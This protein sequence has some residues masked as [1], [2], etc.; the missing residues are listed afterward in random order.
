M[1]LL[2]LFALEDVLVFSVVVDVVELLV[3]LF[4]L[5]GSGLKASGSDMWFCSYLVMHGFGEVDGEVGVLSYLLNFV[6]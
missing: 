3:S 1:V 4:C 6:G 2:L 5:A